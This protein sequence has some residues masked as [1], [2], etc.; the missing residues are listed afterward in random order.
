[1]ITLATIQL[2]EDGVT[3]EIGLNVP[4]NVE[5]ELEVGARFVTTQFQ[6]MEGKTVRGMIQRLRLATLKIAKN[7][8]MVDGVTLEIGLNALLN[9]E[10]ELEAGARLVTTQFQ[11]MEGKTVRG[12]IQR[13]RLATLKTVSYKLE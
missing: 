7:Q 5:E 4:L 3:L 11:K 9:V 8:L 6:K 12:M 13:L 10:E 1:V 2:T